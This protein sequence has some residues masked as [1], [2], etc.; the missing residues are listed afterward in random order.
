[1][2]G[3][4]A[5]RLV[6]FGAR[7]CIPPQYTTVGPISRTANTSY[8]IQQYD[9][10]SHVTTHT[11]KSHMH[12]HSHCSQVYR[13]TTNL[14]HLRSAVRVLTYISTYSCTSGRMYSC[15]ATGRIW[16]PTCT[17]VVRPLFLVWIPLSINCSW[18]FDSAH[19]QGAIPLFTPGNRNGRLTFL[20]GTR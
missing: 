10:C 5:V 2:S 15:T 4:G 7:N 16:I 1:M 20:P 17:K 13:Y 11:L 3:H 14:G 12:V 18:C 8:R 9:A 19:A 6:P